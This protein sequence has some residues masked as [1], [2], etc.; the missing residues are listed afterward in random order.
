LLAQQSA[1]VGTSLATVG[2]TKVS[3]HNRHC[4]CYGCLGIL[5]GLFD[6]SQGLRSQ[7]SSLMMSR[8][9]IT[10]MAFARRFLSFSTCVLD[11]CT[12]SPGPSSGFAPGCDPGSTSSYYTRRHQQ[13]TQRHSVASSGCCTHIT[14]EDTTLL[15]PVTLVVVVDLKARE[16]DLVL[17]LGKRALQTSNLS[18]PLVYRIS[19]WGSYRKELLG[20]LSLHTAQLDQG[21]KCGIVQVINV[22][23]TV[24]PCGQP[25]KGCRDGIPTISLP[26]A[27]IVPQILYAWIAH[28][29]PIEVGSGGARGMSGK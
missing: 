20:F 23:W 2:D 4:Q 15:R 17:V 3:A 8:C 6:S 12:G 27:H 19:S 14:K 18:A 7:N 28:C 21:P 10:T 25:G 29:T 26:P 5:P 24:V 9:S 16:E 22:A 11:C 13:Y 1:E